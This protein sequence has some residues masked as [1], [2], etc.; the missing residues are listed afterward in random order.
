MKKYRITTL[1]TLAGL[2]SAAF[3]AASA[4][5]PAAAAPTTPSGPPLSSTT[6]AVRAPVTNPATGRTYAPTSTTNTAKLTATGGD[7]AVTAYWTPERLKNAIPADT[8][9]STAR[10][11]KQVNELERRASSDKPLTIGSS[12]VAATS[13]KITPQAA[14][15]VTNFS[16]TN[17]KVFFHNQSDGKDYVCSGS[18]IN[19]SSKRLVV[20]AG[21]CVY[22][23]PGNKWH[24]NWVFMPGYSKGA[25][26]GSYQAAVLRTFTDWI[27]YGESG[28]GFNS[29]VAFVT[30]YN[31]S[32]SRAAVVNAVGG[33]GFEWGGGFGFD[34]SIFGYPANRNGGQIMWACW[35]TSGTGWTGTYR[36]NRISGCNFGGGSS[37]GPWLNRYS[38]TSG[39]GYVRSVTSH[40]PAKST[41]YIQ[42]PYFDS[43]VNDL[44]VAANNDWKT[45]NHG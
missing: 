35:G 11:N 7:P 22:G 43:R 38:N 45:H 16:K 25:A 12:P 42:G 27:S 6:T 14:P 15:P 9:A 26:Y 37:G 36:F 2:A 21:H 30:T 3:L 23:A 20:T 40:G 5:T 19:S 8:P 1:V 10:V 32:T 18:S 4:T 34:V 41:A 17:G 29:D 24:S 39:L 44:F 28:R 31:G 13:T 33:H